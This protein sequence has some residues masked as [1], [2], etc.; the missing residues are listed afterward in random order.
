LNDGRIIRFIKADNATYGVKNTIPSNG[1]SFGITDVEIALARAAFRASVGS[2]FGKL[3][4]WSIERIHGQTHRTV[5]RNG[6]LRTPSEWF[7]NR[8]PGYVEILH[9]YFVPPER[10]NDFL[11]RAR[12]LLRQKHGF[13]LLNVTLRKVKKDEITMLSYAREDV[14]GL[15]TLFRYPASR[16]SDDE[17]ARTTRELIAISLDCGGSYYLPYRPHATLDQFR[18]AYPRYRQ[19][20]ELK[21]KYDPE[22]IFQNIFYLGYIRPAATEE[23]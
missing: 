2:D 23:Q 7:A 3:G 6:I 17:M 11:V 20:Y 22:E 15:V 19:F 1:G 16:Q 5:S 9:E 21:R 13:D 14:F 10:L 18:Q 4:R 12:P 8:D